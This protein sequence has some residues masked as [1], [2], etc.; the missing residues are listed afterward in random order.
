MSCRPAVHIQDAETLY[1][2]STR[3]HVRVQH[4]L[5][6]PHWDS[7]SVHTCRWPSEKQAKYTHVQMKPW[8]H[9]F[10][11]NLHPQLTPWETCDFQAGRDCRPPG[12]EA[13]RMEKTSTHPHGTVT[14]TS[15]NCQVHLHKWLGTNVTLNCTKARDPPGLRFSARG[16]EPLPSVSTEIK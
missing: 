7:Q 2:V 3:L 14:C 10:V 1:A 15:R 6:T 13:N 16:E 11:T 12:R 4:P 9:D 8:G 5:G